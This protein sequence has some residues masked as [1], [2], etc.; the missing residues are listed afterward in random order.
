[1]E[2]LHGGMQPV[3]AFVW[4]LPAFEWIVLAGQGTVHPVAGWI[5][6]LMLISGHGIPRLAQHPTARMIKVIIPQYLW[7]WPR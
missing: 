7:W 6:A 5:A 2:V 4:I 1:M 3:T